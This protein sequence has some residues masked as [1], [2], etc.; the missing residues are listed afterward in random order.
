VT[1]CCA[2]DTA[3]QAVCLAAMAVRSAASLAG[4]EPNPMDLVARRY[5]VH[6][7][8]AAMAANC[9]CVPLSDFAERAVRWEQQREPAPC[10]AVLQEALR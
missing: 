7:W 2:E 1:D 8:Y 4:G 10:G 6:A 3:P 9:A 5:P